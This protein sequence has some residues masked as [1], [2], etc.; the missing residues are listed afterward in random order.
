MKQRMAMGMVLGV[1]ALGMAVGCGVRGTGAND[2]PD[3]G[4]GI[5]A[6]DSTE[7]ALMTD[8][9]GEIRRLIDADQKK[10]YGPYVVKAGDAVRA[11]AGPMHGLKLNYY[12]ADGTLLN[13]S[14]CPGDEGAGTNPTCQ[15]KAPKDAVELTAEVTSYTGMLDH[16]LTLRVA[17]TWPSGSVPREIR[18]MIPSDTKMEFGPYAVRAGSPLRAEAGPM[19]NLRL[20][21]FKSDG[22]QVKTSDCPG[23]EGAGTNPT[24]QEKVPAEA[25]EVVAEVSSYT[26]MLDCF[27]VLSLDRTIP[28][29]NLYYKKAIA[30]TRQTFEL[31]DGDKD[32]PD[33]YQV[34]VKNGKL[35]VLGKTTFGIQVSS[36]LNAGLPNN[37]GYELDLRT[38]WLAKVVQVPHVEQKQ[39]IK[40]PLQAGEKAAYKTILGEMKQI[41]QRVQKGNADTFGYRPVPELASVIAYLDFVLS[42][43]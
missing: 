30:L 3:T 25:T 32:S 38:G 40:T 6:A 20:F 11:E 24:C 22:T 28:M 8:I 15:E 9:P 43:I 23:D 5:D 26:D 27:L 19:H 10:E 29:K 42:K 2:G 39:I 21:Y 1:M 7:K 13:S 4:A 37:Y 14:E 33:I 12:G 35:P 16:F 34:A 36:S 17:G 31:R 18:R 41:V